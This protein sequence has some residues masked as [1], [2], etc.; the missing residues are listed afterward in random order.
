MNDRANVRASAV[1]GSESIRPVSD[2]YRWYEGTFVGVWRLYGGYEL[3]T[4]DQLLFTL[5]LF[6]WQSPISVRLRL[7]IPSLERTK[8]TRLDLGDLYF[9]LTPPTIQTPHICVQDPCNQGEGRS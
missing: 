6:T 3:P 7:T 9:T 5:S 4:L 8:E 2:F 1:V